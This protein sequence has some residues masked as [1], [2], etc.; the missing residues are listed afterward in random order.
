MAVALVTDHT[1]EPFTSSNGWQACRYQYDTEGEWKRPC[2][3]P[4]AEHEHAP[5]TDEA[6][7]A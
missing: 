1:Y 5:A 6:A 4:E 3:W 2:G 7:G